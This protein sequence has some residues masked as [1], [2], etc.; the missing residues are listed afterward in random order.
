MQNNL[1][2]IMERAGKK[3]V[4]IASHLGISQATVYNWINGVT[5][6][7]IVEVDR[8]ADFLGVDRDEIYPV[9]KAVAL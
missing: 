6:P 5:T 7:S 3:P 9:S 8:L 4:D 1:K 2:Q